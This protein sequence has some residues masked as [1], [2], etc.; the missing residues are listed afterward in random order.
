M[1]E[2]SLVKFYFARYFFLAFGLLQGLAATMLLLQFQDTPKNRFA[3]FV[4]F[5]LAMIL[6][7]IHFLVFSKVKRV[8]MSK[9]KISVV[10]GHRTK[11]YDWDEV[12]ELKLIHFLNICSLKLKGKKRIYFL[13][14]HDSEALFGLFTAE[15]EFYAKKV[16]A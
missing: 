11:Q 6:F 5:T 8:A 15:P 7:S 16:K 9:K 12:K 2:A 13:P 10:F 1:K 3:V 14:A 4:L